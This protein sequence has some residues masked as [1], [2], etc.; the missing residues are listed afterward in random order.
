MKN[1]A[2][3]TL[4]SIF[5]IIFAAPMVAYAINRNSDKKFF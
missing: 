1:T 3:L 2:I 4:I 5:V